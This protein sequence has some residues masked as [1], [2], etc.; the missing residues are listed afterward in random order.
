MSNSNLDG[1]GGGGGCGGGSSFAKR[2]AITPAR[3]KVAGAPATANWEELPK[4]VVTLIALAIP[5][6]FRSALAWC[7]T[8]RSFRAAQPPIRSLQIGLSEYQLSNGVHMPGRAYPVSTRGLV[9]S[10][11]TPDTFMKESVFWILE[12]ISPRHAAELNQICISTGRPWNRTPILQHPDRSFEDKFTSLQE[13]YINYETRG[14]TEPALNEGGLY[15]AKLIKATAPTLTS[16]TIRC[17]TRQVDVT[18]LLLLFPHLSNLEHLWI[19]IVPFNPPGNPFDTT[20]A[21]GNPESTERALEAATRHCINLV[22]PP[23]IV[24]HKAAGR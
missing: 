1:G 18:L 22:E 6:D 10:F 3:A 14:S 8:C 17:P 16:L 11:K 9:V 13:F 7:S 23:H 21:S 15:V 19:N 2:N 4:E 5:D 12:R 20:R 24:C